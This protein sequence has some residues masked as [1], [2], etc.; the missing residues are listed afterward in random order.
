MDFL[1]KLGIDWKL[2]SAQI[3]QFVLLV[4]VLRKYAYK[5]L[6]GMLEKR[7]KT[8]EQSLAD[9][10]RIEKNL[11]ESSE[12]RER[13]LIQTH[14]DA[15]AI[16][17]EAR[18]NA[19]ALKNKML[20]ET[21]EQLH[22]LQEKAAVDAE[23]M[24]ARMLQDAQSQLADLVITASEHV[25]KEKMTDAHDRKLVEDA[26]ADV[27]SITKEPIPHP[28]SPYSFRRSAADFKGEEK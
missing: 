26:L 14:K 17:V 9:A 5:P 22:T 7:S 25:I 10:K 6:L 13:L 1:G 8:I 12:E 2:L 15:E 21:K 28:A 23:A 19:E 20:D 18:T 16:L 11:A 3:V 4:I 24:K 27:R